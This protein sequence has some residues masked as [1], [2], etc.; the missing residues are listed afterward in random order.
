M[1]G[2]VPHPQIR[3]KRTKKKKNYTHEDIKPR[4]YENENIGNTS[5]SDDYEGEPKKKLKLSKKY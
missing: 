2:G 3:P 1:N 5:S 4:E